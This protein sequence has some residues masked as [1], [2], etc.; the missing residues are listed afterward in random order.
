MKKGLVSAI[1]T[2]HNRLDY[3]KKAI[4][5]VENQTYPNLEIIVVDDSSTDGT[6]E[7]CKSKKNIIYIYIPPENH[8]NGNYARNLG[9]KNSKG[10]YIA[11]LD[12]DDEWYNTKIEKQVLLINTENNCG[13]VYTG[14]NVEVNDGEFYYKIK[15]KPN[16]FGDCSRKSLYTVFS[17]TSTMLFTRQSLYD[18]GFFDENLNFW[19]ET[20]LMIRICQK[21]K[22]F[23]IDDE[24]IL[25]RQK[26]KDRTQLTNN[27][28]GFMEAVNYINE[29]HRN[30]IA[31][32]NSNE[33][34]KRN[35]LI[36]QDL[37]NRCTSLGMN[38][39]SR[40]YLFQLFLL[41]PSLKKFAKVVLNY[42]NPTQLKFKL[43]FDKYFKGARYENK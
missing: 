22:I 14:R 34:K 2:T 30:L 29:K 4:L 13:C 12:D 19:Q 8:V 28:D 37:A 23:S 10:E 27:L 25:Y 20:E 16:C 17:T 1:I 24:L 7:Y 41:F 32:L 18:V 15:V 26:L 38:F 36:Y 3:L 31:N 21:Y 40:K 42:T 5:S 39:K 33:I 6:M 9:I 35:G 43:F 11:F